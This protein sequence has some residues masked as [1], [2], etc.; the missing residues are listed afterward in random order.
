MDSEEPR[1]ILFGFLFIGDPHLSSRVPGFRSDDY[2]RAILHK[3]R[4]CF[5][6]ASSRALVPVLLGDLF[7]WPRENAN[8]LVGEVLDLLPPETLAIAGNHDLGENSLQTHDTL[9]VILKSG[10]LRLLSAEEPWRGEIS[11]REVILGGT[12]WGQKFPSAFEVPT[13]GGARPLVFWATHHDVSF[14]G[15]EEQARQKPRAIPGIDVVVNGHIHRH[16]PEVRSG[17]TL[18]LNPG[19]IAR[20]NRGDL[21]R[22]HRPGVLEITITADGWRAERLEVPHRP[23]DEVFHAALAASASEA[24]PSRFIAG[25]AELVA[26][27]TESGAG[28]EEFIRANST[29]FEP[30]VAFEIGSLA[31]EVLAGRSK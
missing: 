23:F 6:T 18:W 25:L 16:L 20:V 5:E 13:T 2:P 31:A 30:E 11:G 4:W 17:E 19:N 26:R 14:P 1:G 10:R 24:E 27:R 8:W 22:A 21:T 29:Q 3:L 15:Y 9:S 12:S 7:H 28:F